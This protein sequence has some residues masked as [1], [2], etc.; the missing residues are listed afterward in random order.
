MGRRVLRKASR[1]EWGRASCF[2]QGRRPF[3]METGRDRSENN[4]QKYRRKRQMRKSN[5]GKRHPRN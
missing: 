3:L 4:L 5:L 2:S 1:L